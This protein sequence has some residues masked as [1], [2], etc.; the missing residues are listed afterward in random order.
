MGTHG[1]SALSMQSPSM[2]S[3]SSAIGKEH[4]YRDVCPLKSSSKTIPISQQS[5]PF[6]PQNTQFNPFQSS[7]SQD[8]SRPQ[9]PH[10]HYLRASDPLPRQRN[11]RPLHQ[12]SP[13]P[14]QRPGSRRIRSGSRLRNRKLHGRL[15]LPATG[16][17]ER[18]RPR[19]LEQCQQ[20][21]P[22]EAGQHAQGV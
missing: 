19:H 2:S 22:P 21:V 9:S 1:P 20:R 5:I 3:K 11:N 6:Q 13:A 17:P 16:L 4:K 15:A 14:L 12:R 8:V 18:R 10:Q 7:Q